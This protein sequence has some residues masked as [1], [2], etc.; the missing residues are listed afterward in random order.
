MSGDNDNRTI[1]NDTNDIK[2]VG[3]VKGYKNYMDFSDIVKIRELLAGCSKSTA[4]KMAAF[5]VLAG[6]AIALIPGNKT[7]AKEVLATVQGTVSKDSTA[8]TLKIFSLVAGSYEIKIDTDTD[9]TKCSAIT[10]GKSVYVG[11]YKG[12]DNL[13]HA[14]RIIGAEADSSLAKSKSTATQ[15]TIHAMKPNTTTATTTTTAATT[16]TQAPEV[17]TIQVTGKPTDK[18]T[19]SVLYLD[20]NDGVM[21]IAI[22]QSTDTS[23]GYMFT[24]NNKLTANVYRGS[25]ATMHATKVVGGA[26]ASGAPSGGSTVDF[27]GTV[28]GK[29]TEDTLYL[30]TSGGVMTIKLDGSTS[31]NGI[32]GLNNGKSVTVAG[33]VGTDMTWHAVSISA[34]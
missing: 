18:S 31:L 29:S 8:D 33:A 14:D 6:M 30:N 13:L 28:E 21:Y 1:H 16:E 19:N 9:K 2:E 34:K 4:R 3:L 5:A 7:Y 15:S 17:A 12:S 23:G 22:D 20:T 26:K 25:D 24:T 32:K 11:V 27:T 10:P